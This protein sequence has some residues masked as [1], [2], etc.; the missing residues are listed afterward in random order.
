MK[1]I[2]QIIESHYNMDKDE[3]GNKVWYE[4]NLQQALEE[5]GKQCYNQAIQ[6]VADNAEADVICVT[7]NAE[8]QYHKLLMNNEIEVPIITS[9]ILKLLKK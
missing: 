3:D 8:L 7:E 5:Y 2:K 1:T 6:D 4:W 9:S